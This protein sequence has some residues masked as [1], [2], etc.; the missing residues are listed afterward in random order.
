MRN[1]NEIRERKEKLKN[2][3]FDRQMFDGQTSI[4]IRYTCTG[5]K[6]KEQKKGEKQIK[7]NASRK[8]KSAMKI[9]K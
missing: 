7:G 1:R 8:L 6:K 5:R 3:Q 9:T 2:E 4:N